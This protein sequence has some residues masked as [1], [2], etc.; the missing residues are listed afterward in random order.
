[1][2]QPC[3]VVSIALASNQN[4]LIKSMQEKPSKIDHRNLKNELEQ[5]KSKV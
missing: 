5:I 2:D 1:M 4:A 3:K